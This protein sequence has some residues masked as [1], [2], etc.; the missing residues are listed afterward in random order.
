MMYAPWINF[1]LGLWLIISPFLLGHSDVRSAMWNEIIV[2]FLVVIFS[3]K[4]G[5][6]VAGRRASY[7]PGE[8][9]GRA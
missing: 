9:R 3:S 8:Q 6:S 2:G 1:T 4:L 7:G 5:V